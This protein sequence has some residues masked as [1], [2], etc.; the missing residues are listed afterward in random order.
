MHGDGLTSRIVAWPVIDS[1]WLVIRWVTAIGRRFRCPG[2][3]ATQRVAHPGVRR[4]AQYSVAAMAT[5]LHV[6]AARPFGE[7]GSEAEAFALARRRQLPL[8]ERARPGH[9]R[10]TSIRRWLDSLEWVWPNLVLPATGRKA[11]LLGMLTAFGLGASLDEVV[12]AALRAHTL[13][14]LAM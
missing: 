4:G 14:G 12:D 13:G 11:R 8:S 2:C 3:R 1:G 6:V 7:G 5:L 9:P 10:W